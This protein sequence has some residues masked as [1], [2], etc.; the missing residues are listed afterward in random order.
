MHFPEELTTILL[1]REEVEALEKSLEKLLRLALPKI[2]VAGQEYEWTD[3][4]S[5]SAHH[6]RLLADVGLAHL[7]TM[8]GRA[9]ESH[10]NRENNL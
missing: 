7:Y 1:T 4:M 6:Y 5:L 8:L 3:Q 9:R 2:T 10:R